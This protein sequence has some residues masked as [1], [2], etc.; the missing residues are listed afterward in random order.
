MALLQTED[1]SVRLISM[2]QCTSAAAEMLAAPG[3]TVTS[4]SQMGRTVCWRHTL[5]PK[6]PTRKG[7]LSP[8]EG[9]PTRHVYWSIRHFT[10]SWSGAVLRTLIRTSGTPQQYPAFVTR[11]NYRGFRTTYIFSGWLMSITPDQRGRVLVQS[12][13]SPYSSLPNESITNK[14]LARKAK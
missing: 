5:N 4:D 9:L 14:A 10:R 13:L 6:I 12:I 7:V 8:T 1:R 3:T 11:T 2:A